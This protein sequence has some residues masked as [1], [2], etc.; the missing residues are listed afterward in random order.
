MSSPFRNGDNN[1]REPSKSKR[2]VAIRNNA[3]DM[4][5]RLQIRR[6]KADERDHTQTG[7]YLCYKTSFWWRLEYYVYLYLN[8]STTN[9]NRAGGE[10]SSSALIVLGGACGWCGCTHT[11]TQTHGLVSRLWLRLHIL[12]H[13]VLSR[14]RRTNVVHYTF[15]LLIVVMRPIYG[16]G[17][18]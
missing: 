2:S 4:M 1:N 17:C 13:R 15:N 12:T 9:D 18:F 8:L 6:H 16:Y 11:H 14:R 7:R 10:D 5:S 3:A